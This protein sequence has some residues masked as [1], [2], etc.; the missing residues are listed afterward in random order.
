[1]KEFSPELAKR[2]KEEE[3][4]QCM[5][6]EFNKVIEAEQERMIFATDEHEMVRCQERIKALRLASNFPQIVIERE[7]EPKDESPIIGGT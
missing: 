6:G 4:W 7:E 3:A 5:V 1:M 2:L